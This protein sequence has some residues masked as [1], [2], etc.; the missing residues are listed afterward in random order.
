MKK[1]MFEKGSDKARVS[2]GGIEP[3]V[4][5]PEVNEEPVLAGQPVDRAP[6]FQQTVAC[7]P[8]PGN[9][10]QI[11]TDEKNERRRF[12]VCDCNIEDNPWKGKVVWEYTADEEGKPVTGSAF[13]ARGTIGG[14]NG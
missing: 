1:S 5:K 9:K 2:E 13:S 4:F 10:L 12:A 7:P 6:N 11:Q 14:E 3:A 8:H